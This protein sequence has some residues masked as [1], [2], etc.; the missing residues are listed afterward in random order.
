MS[1][2]IDITAAAG[3][4]GLDDTGD[5][6]FGAA[7]DALMTPQG[8]VESVE[9]SIEFGSGDA[10]DEVGEGGEWYDD[11]PEELREKV[12][13]K[14]YKTPADL[15]RAYASAESQLGEF[16]SQ[17]GSLRDEVANLASQRG[18]DEPRH[19]SEPVNEVPT[20]GQVAQYADGISRKIDEGELDVGQGISD[21]MAVVAG[22]IERRES[23]LLDQV[24]ARI[25]DRTAP[26]E[27]DSFRTAVAREIT[28][29]KRE[30]G[31]EVYADLEP[32]VKATLRRWEQQQ[33]GFVQNA[34]AVRAAFGEV[35]L[36][37]QTQQRREAAGGVLERSGRGAS[38]RGPSP[39]ETIIGEMEQIGGGGMSGGL[40]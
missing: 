25:G 10:A 20:M 13:A 22:V 9:G 36:K 32:E 7:E 33:P 26:L 34:R 14:G 28:A 15:A 37:T 12:I 3:N 38:R 23:W 1:D 27:Q 29:L 2:L 40:L 6:D 8:P 35:F 39:A 30:V 21:L 19:S 17:I 5:I 24:D 16:G 18:G 11:L 31:D 4:G